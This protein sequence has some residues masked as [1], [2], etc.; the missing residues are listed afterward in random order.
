MA[1]KYY[2]GIN[3]SG[4]IVPSEDS[5]YNLGGPAF[6]FA[7]V[8]ADNLYGDGSN[9]T[10]IGA[11]QSAL[12]LTVTV[13]NK[14]GGSLAKGTVVHAAPS[15]NPPSGN[16]IEV[17]AADFDTVANM[18]GLGILNETLANDAEGEA[19]MFGAVSGID[20]SSFIAGTELYVGN[21]GALTGTKPAATDQ[22]IQKIAVVIKSH[23]TNGLIKVFGAGRTNDVPNKIDRTIQFDANQSFTDNSLILMG[24]GDMFQIGHKASYSQIA[25]YEGNLYIDNNANNFDIVL[26][27]DDGNGGLA[28]YY[29]IDGSEGLNRFQKNILI[30]DSV[31][32]SLGNS[33]DLKLYHDGTNSYINE[34]GTG[35]LVTQAS[36]YFLRVGGTNNTNNALV[37]A[38]SGTVTLYYANSAKLATTSSGINVTG[39]LEVNGNFTVSGTTVID[40]SQNI[41]AGN[42]TLSGYLRGG[43][44]FVI[45]PSAHGDNTGTVQILGNLIVEGE[46]TTINSTTVTIDDKN[47]VLASG[48]ADANAANG[49]GITIDGANAAM[50]YNS[51]SDTFDFNKPFNL[52]TGGQNIGI[53]INSTDA[54]SYIYFKDSN[55]T[56]YYLG[57]DN[58]IFKVIDSGNSPIL[59]INSS[60]DATF[61]GDVT[62]TTFVGNLTGAASLNV[63]K[64]GDTMTGT[65]V[66]STSSD[67]KIDLRTPSG[68]TSDWNYINF[69]GRDGARDSYIGI[70]ADG[71]MKIYSDKN[72]YGISLYSY[73]LQ[74]DSNVNIATGVLQV[75]STTVIDASRNVSAGTISGSTGT[76]SGNVQSG[77]TFIIQNAGGK[78][79]QTLFDGADG[80][81]LRYYNGS[82]WQSNAITV[83]TTNQVTLS[84]NVATTFTP[85]TLG[86]TTASASYVKQDFQTD[87]IGATQAYIIAYGSGN[88]QD[89]SFAIKNTASHATTNGTS[90]D[91]WFQNRS[92]ETLRLYANNTSEFFGDVTAPTFIG[93]IQTDSITGGTIDINGTTA[94]NL[95]YNGSTQLRID[96]NGVNYLGTVTFA[97]DGISLTDTHSTIDSFFHANINYDG[98]LYTV[99][100]NARYGADYIQVDGYDTRSNTRFVISPKATT[101]S[102]PDLYLGGDFSTTAPNTLT[103]WRN[104][105]INASSVKINNAEVATRAWVNSNTTLDDVTT[106][107]NST[108]NSISVGTVS[109]SGG[110]QLPVTG[111]TN[112]V[113]SYFNTIQLRTSGAA[114]T[115]Q[116]GGNGTGWVNNNLKVGNGNLEVVGN[117]DGQIFRDIDNTAYYVDPANTGT[118][119]NFAGKVQASQVGV[120]NIVTNKVVKF[121][122]SILDD[123]IITDDGT[124]IDVAGK[125]QAD[126]AFI[127]QGVDTSNSLPSADHAVL[128]GYGLIGNRGTFYITNPNTV[129]I[130]TGVSHNNDPAALF[131]SSLITLKKET[132]VENFLTI[133]RSADKKIRFSDTRTGANT[134]SIE[135]DASQ[136]YLYNETTASSLLEIENNGNIGVGLSPIYKFDVNGTLGVRSG[137]IQTNGSTA[138]FNFLAGGTAKGAKVAFLLASSSYSATPSTGQI[139]AIDSMQSPIYY[140]YNNTSYYVNPNADSSFGGSL[141]LVGDLDLNQGSYI[142]FYGNDSGDH[143]I[144]SRNS[145]GGGDDD[146]RINSYGAVYINLD[147]NNNNTSTANFWI[148]RH[149]STGIISDWLF[150]V[151]G[152]TGDTEIS[153]DLT[154]SGSLNVGG[155][156]ATFVKIYENQ[157]YVASDP[158]STGSRTNYGQGLTVYEGY[159]TGTNRPH[160]YDTTL[161]IMSTNNQGFELSADWVSTSKTPLKIR[162]LRDCCQGW[163]NWAEV[164]TAEHTHSQN[165]ITTGSMQAGVFYD[166][167]NTGY[168]VDPATAGNGTVLNGVRINYLGLGTSANTSGNYVINMGGSIDMNANNI[169]YINQL[170]FSDGVRF[171]DNG[172]DSY[173]NFKYAD[174]TQGGIKLLD[175]A[176]NQMGFLFANSGNFGLLSADGTWAVRTTNSGTVI[177]HRLDTPIFYDSDNTAYYVNPNGNSVL[178]TISAFGLSVNT[179]A[180]SSNA[181]VTGTVQHGGLVMTS[182][183]NVD[184]IYEVGMSF[185]LTAD[186]WTDTG[187]NSTDLATGTYVVQVFVNDY[188][189]GGG[190]YSEYYSGTMSWYA[191]TTNSTNV[192]EIVLHNAGHASNFSYIQLRTQR[193]SSGG[194]DLMLQ[195]KQ[196]FTH[197]TALDGTSGKQ[198]VFKFRRLI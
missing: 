163:S 67:N 158:T 62:A 41:T 145:S 28:T 186:T 106:N 125:V 16:V 55:A 48:A 90:G 170:H 183:T 150:K 131:T 52:N 98:G 181:T 15:A 120:T 198:M 3:I 24:D 21:N 133:S 179:L 17:I 77:D 57:A 188:N 78:R 167:N 18:P 59:Q 93:D 115:I 73:G 44:T 68:D 99:D 175:S 123:S 69:Y 63:L 20:T 7:N 38:N 153:G 118:S 66:I 172:D 9:I 132:T 86:L 180:V 27:S 79:W 87:T 58:G 2:S 36:D 50:A 177:D 53:T 74:I 6:Y 64:S 12:T 161:Q 193:H 10:N 33:F 178:N 26:R 11:S 124:F 8:Y 109:A 116:I 13:K 128:S 111:Y 51:T 96:S 129:Q 102:N 80:W 156:A 154:V 104:V 113:A 30:S 49:A 5:T 190:H 1:I 22:L 103:T 4:N 97:N 84:K 136:I 19:V 54:G 144:T 95:Q 151:D 194:D 149:G 114:G 117:I 159:S 195:V 42:M 56:D 192:D 61:Y 101:T 39:D 174:A 47:L 157:N 81:N 162:S 164:M 185:T 119:A 82:S 141:G 92:N 191:S 138:S 135:H 140:D 134:F 155:A 148:G 168:Q 169:D 146:L 71:D 60:K 126:N 143:G 40:S 89:G 187:I 100:S 121:N 122:G 189:A 70:D 88:T 152:E 29:Y 137:Q 85:L 14:S 65:L 160:T 31:N 37:A 76:F 72:S 166:Q 23:A 75:G 94:I 171:Y 107:G 176:N 112:V 139:W 173:L 91:I 110:L 182:G 184:Q 45:D 46:T 83:D 127:V 35:S 165:F 108:S 34:T 197:T 147:S 32:L 43:E 105:E 196:N 142:T 25:T 130:G